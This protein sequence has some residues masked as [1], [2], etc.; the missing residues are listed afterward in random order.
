LRFPVI[1][2]GLKSLGS[3]SLADSGQQTPITVVAAKSGGRYVVIDGY[4]RMVQPGDRR[5]SPMDNLNHRDPLA[6]T[7]RGCPRSRC[8]LRYHHSFYAS[9]GRRFR[10][11]RPTSISRQL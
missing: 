6:G 5:Q 3:W 8:S 11:R 2:Q 7:V 1:I 10:A 4:R 9:T